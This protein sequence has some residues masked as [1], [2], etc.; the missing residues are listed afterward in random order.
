MSATAIK[1]K[2]STQQQRDL[3]SPSATDKQSQNFSED[4][5][6]F[7]LELTRNLT[8]KSN[9]STYKTICEKNSPLISRINTT[10]TKLL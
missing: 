10:T 9:K 6:L 8:T 7:Y 3:Q 4:G 5:N 1:I 2:S